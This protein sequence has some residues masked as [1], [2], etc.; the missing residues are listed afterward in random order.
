MYL[1]LDIYT[2]TLADLRVGVHEHVGVYECNA[3][4]FAD[5]NGGVL[6]KFP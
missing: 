5:L 1:K 6:R 4:S 3:T 2:S